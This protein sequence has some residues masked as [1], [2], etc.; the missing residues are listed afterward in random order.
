MFNIPITLLYDGQHGKIDLPSSVSIDDIA[1]VK[2]ITID[3][4]CSFDV[5]SYYHSDLVPHTEILLTD[6]RV[7]PV[8]ERYGAICMYLD[9][10]RQLDKDF[11][12]EQRP[13]VPPPS[14]RS[15]KLIHGGI[16]ATSQASTPAS[17][18][19]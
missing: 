13:T 17:R 6:G 12:T 9:I 15:L 14:E 4:T 2:M 16:C 8:V 3:S 18:A 19:H 7:L 11:S 10:Y 1:T 5:E